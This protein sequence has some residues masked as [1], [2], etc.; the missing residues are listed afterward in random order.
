MVLPGVVDGVSGISTTR[1][2]CRSPAPDRTAA[3]GFQAQALSSRSSSSSSDGSSEA[4]P[5]ITTWQVV[6]AQ[7]ISAGVFDST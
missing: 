1:S 5:R 2:A 4:K 3:R 6:Q 7:D